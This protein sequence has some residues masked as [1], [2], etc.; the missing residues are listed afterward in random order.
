[1]AWTIEH[2]AETEGNGLPTLRAARRYKAEVPGLG[3]A[4]IYGYCTTPRGIMPSFRSPNCQCALFLRS[5]RFPII[6]N[7]VDGLFYGIE[8]RRE[9]ILG[10]ARREV[11]ELM[12]RL[13]LDPEVLRRGGWSRLRATSQGSTEVLRATYGAITILL[14]RRAVGEVFGE[15]RYVFEA[16]GS[17]RRGREMISTSVF[18]GNVRSMFLEIARILAAHDLR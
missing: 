10:E 7:L 9:G 17:T 5:W 8:R 13:V 4:A 18:D 14:K 15:R 1:M 16:V 11:V 6:G 12:E 3:G 2:F